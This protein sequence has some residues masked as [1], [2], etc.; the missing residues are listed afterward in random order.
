M[1]NEEEPLLFSY[2][3]IRSETVKKAGLSPQSRINMN[4][5]EHCNDMGAGV[6]FER[7]RIIGL[8][9]CAASGCEAMLSVG[10]EVLVMSQ[11]KPRRH[12]SNLVFCSI[13]CQRR[14]HVES[15]VYAIRRGRK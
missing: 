8:M 6:L 9:I 15:G 14:N 11:N 12:T 2:Q 4:H 13:G 1:M 5:R 7:A 10:D 3:S